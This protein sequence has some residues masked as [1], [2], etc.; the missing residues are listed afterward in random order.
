MPSANGTMY[1][2]A[3]MLEAIWCPAAAVVPMREMNSAMKVN[4]DTSTSTASPAGMPRRRKAPSCG[5][6]GRS[7]RRHSA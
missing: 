4:D 2:T 1:S 5:Q 3:A 6:S 7:M